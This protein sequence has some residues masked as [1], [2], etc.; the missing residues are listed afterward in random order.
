MDLSL[1]LQKN[2][3]NI[4]TPSSGSCVCSNLHAINLPTLPIANFDKMGH[5]YF[6][7]GR[8]DLM[9][10]S[11]E[12]FSGPGK[13]NQDFGGKE[14]QITLWTRPKAFMAGKS[15]ELFSGPGKS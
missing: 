3:E 15:G 14:W 4:F 5:I 6:W 13:S 7:T 1:T 9:G 11:G 2:Y 12:L 8:P 10:K